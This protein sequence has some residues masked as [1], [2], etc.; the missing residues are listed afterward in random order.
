MPGVWRDYTVQAQLRLCLEEANCPQEENYPNSLCIKVNG[1]LF[2]LLGYIPPPKNGMEQK[3]PGWPLNIT[4]LVRLSS[5]VPNQISISWA[6]EIGKNYSMSI[7]HCSL[8]ITDIK[9]ESCSL[10]ELF[11]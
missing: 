6:S 5:A 1:E 2:P 9:N 3:L 4:S 7:Y 10:V 8:G 11:N